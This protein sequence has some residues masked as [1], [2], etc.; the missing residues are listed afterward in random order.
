[1]LGELANGQRQEIA[2]VFFRR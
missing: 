1:M 2:C